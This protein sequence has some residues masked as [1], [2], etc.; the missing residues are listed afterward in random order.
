[1]KEQYLVES[2]I[3]SQLNFESLES[4][5]NSDLLSSLKD[6]KE[7]SF[8]RIIFMTTEEFKAITEG[9]DPTKIWELI[10]K[11]KTNVI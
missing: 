1:M 10:K 5:I 4:Q 8:A 7:V 9:I 2:E 11:I 6:L 3:I